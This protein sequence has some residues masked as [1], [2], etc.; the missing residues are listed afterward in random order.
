M[1]LDICPSKCPLDGFLDWFLMPWAVWISRVVPVGPWAGWISRVVPWG[2]GL[3]GFLYGLPGAL[4]C[5]DFSVPWGLVLYGFL[6]WFP[7]ALGWWISRQVPWSLGLNGFV[8]G[9][10]GALSWTSESL[11]LAKCSLGRIALEV[12]PHKLNML[13]G[14]TGL[15]RSRRHTADGCLSNLEDASLNEKLENN[16]ASHRE[17]RQLE[18]A[19]ARVGKTRAR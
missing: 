16:R 13:A 5:M 7:G 2:L 1:P 9:F 15:E 6:E 18:L 12:S 19:Q 3:D 11:S 4:C 14:S 17:A 10:P 8:E